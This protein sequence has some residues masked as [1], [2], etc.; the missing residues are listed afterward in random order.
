[1]ESYIQALYKF[2]YLEEAD[3]YYFELTDADD[4]EQFFGVNEELVSLDTAISKLSEQGWRAV[5][6]SFPRPE[7]AYLLVEAKRTE[8]DEDETGEESSTDSNW[9]T[10]G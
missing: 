8:T 4:N 9:P 6:L 10:L 1:M 7:R 3:E 2:I 5:S